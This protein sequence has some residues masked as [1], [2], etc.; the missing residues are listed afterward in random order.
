[1]KRRSLSLVLLLI[2][3]ALPLSASQFIDMPF[4]EVA[5][6][7]KYVVRGTVID[8]F[9]T[10]DESREVIWTYAT[11]RVSRYFGETTGPDTLVVRN[12][13][14]TVDGYSQQVIGFPELRLGENVV[15]MLA[16]DGS[17]LMLNAY[18]QGKFLVRQRGATEVLVSDP[19]K[20]GEIRPQLSPRFDIS[21][22]AVADEGPAFTIEEFAAMVDDA[23]A[24]AERRS[25]MRQQQ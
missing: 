21:T 22:N 8:T 17:N 6:G 7:A 5:R 9:A 16:E 15:V 4:D 10:W 2:V 13:G 18:N 3:S 25:V 1:M 24:G 11:I 14:G 20:Q 23:R 12:A 19:V